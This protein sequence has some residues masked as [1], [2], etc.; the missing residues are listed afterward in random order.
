MADMETTQNHIITNSN[1]IA[2]PNQSSKLP[3]SVGQILAIALPIAA[4][5]LFTAIF[6]P[7]YVTSKKK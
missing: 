4:L 6:V 7:I 1:N 3:C 2:P 5:G